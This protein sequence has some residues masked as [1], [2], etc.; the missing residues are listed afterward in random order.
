VLDDVERRPLVEQPPRE[1]A[2]PAPV[3]LDHIDLDEGAGILLDF[4]RRG[5]L[6]RLQPH[7]DVADPCRLAG[8]EPD[9]ARIAVALV[10]QAE[11]GDAVAHRRGGGV[12][13][14]AVGAD[15]YHS[16]IGAGV[17]GIPRDVG[18]DDIVDDRVPVGLLALAGR[19]RQ[20][21]RGHRGSGR[22]DHA[23][24]VQAS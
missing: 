11:H 16:R 12:D 6:A 19:Q 15:S 24:G 9:L 18:R 13:R 10:E 17:A 4:P 1:H 14:A 21:Q 20:G 3:G 22:R 8:L 2:P 7:D 23:S 5:L